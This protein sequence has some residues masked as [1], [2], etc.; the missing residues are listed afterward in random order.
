MPRSCRVAQELTHSVK[1]RWLAALDAPAGRKS[2][3]NQT[4]TV[5]R[6]PGKG[7]DA[8]CRVASLHRL[9]GGGAYGMNHGIEGSE[10]QGTLLYGRTVTVA[11]LQSGCWSDESDTHETPRMDASN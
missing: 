6:A 5:R 1:R 8:C 2:N 4:W 10:Y 3:E 11:S 9:V 7:H